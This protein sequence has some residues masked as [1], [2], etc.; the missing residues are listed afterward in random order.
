MSIARVPLNVAET[1]PIV[2]LLVQGVF[3]IE[4]APL[5]GSDSS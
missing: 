4:D 2:I 5:A 3:S 1:A